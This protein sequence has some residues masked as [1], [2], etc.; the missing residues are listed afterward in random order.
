M[1]FET[2]A[3]EIAQSSTSPRVI[4]LSIPEIRGNEWKY[5]KDCLDTGWVSSVGAYVNELEE[6]LAAIVGSRSA[7]AVCNGTSALHIALLVGGVQP[8]DEVLVS[9]LT[10]I[11]PVNAIRYAGAL[12]VLMDAEPEYWQLDSRKLRKFVEEHCDFSKGVLRNRRS[13]RRISAILPVHI[14]GHPVDMDAINSLAAEY[15]LTVIEDATESLGAKYRGRNAGALG[16]IGCFS[17]N[18]NKI[19]TTGGGGAIVT[20]NE[21]WGRRAKYLSTQAKDDP[22]EFRHGAIGYNYRLTNI[23]AALGCAQL[24]LLES[25]VSKKKQIARRYESEL[26]GVPGITIMPQA[27]WAESV[28]WLYTILIDE[29]Q[30]GR[31]PRAV[32]SELKTRGIE[33]RPLWQPM[34]QSSVHRGCEAFDCEVADWL[35]SRA[36]SLPSSVG[37]TEADQGYVLESLLACRR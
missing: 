35:Y 29:E 14:L 15:G 34:H 12:P 11:A 17:F 10:F 26:K 5:V 3:R 27:A 25:Y 22:L 23:Q 13:G 31:S 7:T 37:L 6:A 33:S 4:P 21:D 18:G 19:I 20:N 16:H 30:F 28:F 2:E 36:L 8:N 1:P 32:L 9:T 24:E